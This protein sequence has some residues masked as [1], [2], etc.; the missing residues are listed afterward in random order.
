MRL[1]CTGR[2]R[3]FP[4]RAM[5]G[6]NGRRAGQQIRLM[7]VCALLACIGQCDGGNLQAVGG[8]PGGSSSLPMQG[9]GSRE[10]QANAQHIA[11]HGKNSQ[12]C[13]AQRGSKCSQQSVPVLLP[14]AQW[15]R[16]S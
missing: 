2:L 6:K 4:N 5:T 7:H 13:T 16:K 11:K 12:P 14:A 3:V 15:P 10:A 1:L 8:R 9:K